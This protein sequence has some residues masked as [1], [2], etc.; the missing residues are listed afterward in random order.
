MEKK[1]FV[2]GA[3]VLAAAGLLVKFIGAVYR[4]PLNN[5]VGVEGMRYYDIVYRYYTWLLVI[6]SA[7]IPTAISKL[8]SERATL[9]DLRGARAI[10]LAA[11]KLLLLIGIGTALIMFFGADALAAISYP[12]HAQAEIARQ[13]MSFR[14]LSPALLFVSLMCAYRGFL[15]GM[16]QMTGT[17]IS[18]IAEQAGKLAFGFTLAHHFLPLGPEYAAM[19]ALAGVSISELLALAVILVF[20]LRRR[21]EFA[22]QPSRARPQAKEGFGRLSRRILAIAVPVTIGASVMPIMGIVDGAFIIRILESVGYTVAQAGE[23]YSLLYSFV[24]PLINMPA[25]LTAA[26]AISL[27]PAV[28]AFLAQKDQARVR[29]ASRTGLKLALVIGTPCAV[30]LFALAEP[31]LGLLFSTLTPAQLSIAA[32]LLRTA[33]IGVVFLSVVQT[34]T[35]LLQGMGKPMVPVMNLVAGGVVK[36]VTLFFL[37]RDPSLNIQGAALSTVLCYAVAGILDAVYLVRYAD[38]RLVPFDVFG[39]PLLSSALM[40]IAAGILY[41]FLA[42]RTGAAVSTLGSVLV[43]VLLYGILAV[44]LRMFSPEDLAFLPGGGRLRRFFGK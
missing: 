28:S 39:K 27:V 33:S 21:G 40:G 22:P 13:A 9:G 19:G 2:R 12:A 31:I 32:G 5:I 7:G 3:A 18:Q 11:Q 1:S 25:V 38:L 4:I 26:L 15:Q 34:L 17:A 30:G 23:L 44:A 42:S 20:H 8:V 37:T 14:A 29:A 16:Q 6:S 35:G 10:F 24:T 43:G 36:L 41:R